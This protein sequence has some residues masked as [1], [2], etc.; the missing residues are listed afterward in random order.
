M[1]RCIACKSLYGEPASK[2]A[3]KNLVPDLDD[4]PARF[5]SELHYLCTRCGALWLRPLTVSGYRRKP[6][7]WVER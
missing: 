7:V 4:P 2:P 1:R 3:H 5:K 6:L